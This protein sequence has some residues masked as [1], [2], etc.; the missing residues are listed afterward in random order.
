MTL[1]SLALAFALA[2]GHTGPEARAIAQA[3][4][5]AC[6][7]S[8]CVA[9][10]AVYAEDETRWTLNAKH[11]D[12]GIAVGPWQVHDAPEGDIDAQA[13][14]WVAVRAWSLAKCGNL[15]ALASGSCHRGTRLARERADEAWYLAYSV[16]TEAHE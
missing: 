13:R 2:L 7:D 9:D 14:K 11:G 10:A 15:A 5:Q 12:G 3:I 6:Q 16:A 4:A 1:T 8:A